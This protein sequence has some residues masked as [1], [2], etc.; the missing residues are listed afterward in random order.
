VLT[1]RFIRQSP[2]LLNLVLI[3]LLGLIGSWV[4]SQSRTLTASLTVLLL[5]VVYS[6]VAFYAYFRW[7]YWL[8]MV[9]PLAALVVTHFALL[10]YRVVFEQ[11]ER[12]R[13]RNVFARMVSPNIVFEL[14]QAENLSLVGARREVTVFF[15]DVRGFTALTDKSHAR[16]EEYVRQHKLSGPEAVKY[17]DTQ[18]EEVLATV[19]QYLSAIAKQ[20]QAHAGT[21][22]KYIGDC[23]MA[24]WGAP[25]LNTKHA[26][27]C[28]RAA[29]DAQRAIA[30]L[31]IDRAKK[32]PLLEPLYMGSGINTG[33]VNIGLMGSEAN[34]TYTVFGREVNLASRLEHFSERRIVIS[35]ATYEEIQREDKELAALCRKLEDAT[36]KGFDTPVE[37]YEVLWAPRGDSE[38]VAEQKSPK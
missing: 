16:A 5:A 35:K 8:P 10:T 17:F 14:L 36:L 1:G 38:P 34:S 20:V 15:S 7:R 18:A 30:Q 28:V 31:N 12:R 2:L 24:F 37:V 23:V 3:G 9:L 33:T 32:N 13:I 26:A 11:K 21:L 19:N 4:T 6:G 22:D 25:T 29:I 27:A